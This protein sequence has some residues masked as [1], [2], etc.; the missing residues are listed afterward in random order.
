M[1][2]HYLTWPPA[3][4]D[5]DPNRSRT[6]KVISGC[7]D[8]RKNYNVY[9]VCLKRNCVKKNHSRTPEPQVAYK[10]QSLM[11]VEIN[12]AP[13]HACSN[14]DTSFVVLFHRDAV[15]KNDGLSGL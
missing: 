12:C 14:E 1:H 6:P 10:H 4:F 3:T 7:F 13:R 15:W 11:T 5:V 9:K 8:D 2:R